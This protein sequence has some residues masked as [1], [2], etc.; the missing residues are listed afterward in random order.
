MPILRK[1]T[2]GGDSGSRRER[3]IVEQNND[4]A[5]EILKQAEA[6]KRAT[7]D[8]T[9]TKTYVMEH[10]FGA[11]M[12]V[13]VLVVLAFLNLIILQMY[14]KRWFPELEIQIDRNKAA[15][16]CSIVVVAVVVYAFWSS[17]VKATNRAYSSV[18]S[19]FLSPLRQWVLYFP[20]ISI[21]VCTLVSVYENA[22]EGE[23]FTMILIMAPEHCRDLL[24]LIFFFAFAAYWRY[25]DHFTL[26]AEK[27]KSA[28]GKKG[29]NDTLVSKW[30]SRI[31]VGSVAVVI[32]FMLFMSV[33]HMNNEHYAEISELKAADLTNSKGGK[34]MT[35]TQSIPQRTLKP[36]P[37][38]EINEDQSD[39]RKV[40]HEW[41]NGCFKIPNWSCFHKTI[42]TGDAKA[43][44]GTCGA[45]GANPN[46]EVDN[47]K[48]TEATRLLKECVNIAKLRGHNPAKR[49]KL[50]CAL[51]NET[52]FKEKGFNYQFDVFTGNSLHENDVE[53]TLWEEYTPVERKRA[54]KNV[55][56][57]A[58]VISD[59]CLWWVMLEGL[60]ILCLMACE[61]TFFEHLQ[62]KEHPRADY[63]LLHAAPG[64]PGLLALLTAC[65]AF[66]RGM[67]ACNAVVEY[68]SNKLPSMIPAVHNMDTL[69]LILLSAIVLMVVVW[70]KYVVSNKTRESTTKGDP[71]QPAALNGFYYF[72]V[73]G[74]VAPFVTAATPFFLIGVML[75]FWVLPIFNEIGFQSFKS[76]LGFS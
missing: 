30:I 56:A 68:V 27:G 52:E 12:S 5:G 44:S 25:K 1:D 38:R 69:H 21:P 9:G 71:A 26:K 32:L 18:D 48:V 45:P 19:K 58:F 42:K 6:P 63:F 47:Y 41:C 64:M 55:R 4:N 61:K 8:N 62:S 28:K 53:A 14:G 34:W 75:Y 7:A 43:A 76:A 39:Q 22:P 46:T 54:E 72:V 24:L 35:K 33:Q 70:C 73:Y 17:I 59:T 66:A 2:A 29:S 3:R 37:Q 11:I 40:V 31:A 67:D 23:F 20:T 50:T 60:P 57:Y 16:S 13:I 49:C 65:F 51:K 74:V 36:A 10:A 15:W